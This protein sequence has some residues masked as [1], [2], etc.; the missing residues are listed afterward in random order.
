M[1]RYARRPGVLLAPV[2]E[3]WAAFSGASGETALLN[4]ES[5]AILEV[6]AE[7][8][9]DHEAVCRTLAAD[10]G[11]EATDIAAAVEASWLSLV[12]AGMVFDQG[13]GLSC[14]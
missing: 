11:L 12:L 5:A 4:D 9:A 7:G 13:G 14:R 3:R 2:G 8:P 6:L 10:S 1:P